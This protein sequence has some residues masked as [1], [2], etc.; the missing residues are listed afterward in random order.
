MELLKLY[1]RNLLENKNNFLYHGSKYKFSK[2]VLDYVNFDANNQLGPGIYLT[3]DPKEARNYSYPDGYVYKLNL[4]NTS[5]L[6]PKDIEINQDQIEQLLKSA[7][8]LTGS[9][10]DWDE[11]PKE[12]YKML[13]D[14][15]L[16]NDDMTEALQ[17]VWIETYKQKEKDF[18]SNCI[19]VGID[20]IIVQTGSSTHY[21]L[22][23]PSIIQIVGSKQLKK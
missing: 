13:L 7:P 23:N 8:D 20:G 18:C 9:L 17:S 10:S 15:I 6:V 12:A 16:N 19:K 14:S 1:I 2:F 11:D 4:I 21:V 22:Y 3:N 5:N